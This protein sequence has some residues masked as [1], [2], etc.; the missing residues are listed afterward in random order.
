MARGQ[1]KVWRERRVRIAAILGLGG[2]LFGW[3][4]LGGCQSRSKS[5]PIILILLDTVRRD[6]LGCYGDPEKPTPNLDALAADGVRFDQAIASSGWTLPS[7]ASLLT[8]TWPTLHGA[9]GKG[10]QLTPI[11]PELATAPEVLS[12]AGYKTLG[13]ANAAFVSPLLGMNRGFDAFDHRHTYNWNA[14]NADASVDVLF[15]M[16]QAAGSDRPLFLML[17]LFDAH[18]D[19]DPPGR[20]ATLH[21]GGRTEPALPVT[22][23]TCEELWGKKLGRRGPSARDAEYIRDLYR[24]EIGF[25]DEQVGRLIEHLRSQSM[26]DDAMI[27]VTADHGEEFWDHDGFEHGHTLYDELVRVPLLIKFPESSASTVRVVEDQ[28]RLLDV[29]PTVFEVFGVETPE[30]FVGASLLPLVQG[31][32]TGEQDRPALCEST[33]YGPEKVALRK[34]GYKY[35]L[36]VGAS[37]DQGELYRWTTDPQEKE[38]LREREREL[39]GRYHEDLIEMYRGLVQRAGEFSRRKPVDLTPGHVEMLKSLGYIR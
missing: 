19:Y 33:L 8:G 31:K 1:E 28:V 26:Y 22:M 25:M 32:A 12:D 15:D 23:K 6:A 20:F 13:V 38:N 37:A 30:S 9:R 39:A 10:A 34:G 16:M 14:R 7:V 35:V 17:H 4:V 29:M 18:L 3:V 5:G 27:I 24:G 11:R 21:T 36:P 2:L